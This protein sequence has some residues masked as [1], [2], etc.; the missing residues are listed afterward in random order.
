MPV[1]FL[2]EQAP[3]K[4]K[5]RFLDEERNTQQFGPPKE[6]TGGFVSGVAMGA[7]DPVYGVGQMVPRGMQWLTSLGGN[8]PNTVSDLYGKSAKTVD[9]AVKSREEKYQDPEG[10]DWGR[11][12]GNVASPINFIPAGS[13]GKVSSLGGKALAGVA[14]GAAFGAAQ[15]VAETENYTQKKAWQTGLGAAGGA[16]APAI[17]AGVNRLMNPQTAPA[18]KGLL[19]EGVKMTPGQMAGGFVKRAED[20]FTSIPVLGDVINS[21]KNKSIE[22]LNLT[23]INRALKPIGQS[24]PKGISAGREAIGYVGDTLG[25]AYD[26]LLPKLT[27][28]VD[29]VFSDDLSLIGDMVNADDVM[30][31]AEKTKFASII[32]NSLKKRMAANGGMTGQAIKDIE[33]E[34][35]EKAATFGHGTIQERQLA[36]SLREVQSS[37]REMLERTNPQYAKELKAIN[38]GYANFK[39]VQKAAASTGTE[40]GVFT[41][42]QLQ[43]AVKAGDRSKDKGAFAKGT[44]LMQDLSDPA[45]ARLPSKIN[46]SGTATRALFSLGALGAGGY[47]ADRMG[48]DPLAYGPVLG[49]AAMYTPAGRRM[50]QALLTERPNSVRA[51][52][53]AAAKYAPYLG[54][55]LTAPLANQK[56]D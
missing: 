1:R 8:Y 25:K 30:N 11:L 29:D 53:S 48:I 26:D 51:I 52:G 38:K 34:L 46:D 12:T 7:L 20:A 50:A 2:D 17:G 45:K 55:P 36:D 5:I 32:E 18:V 6:K 4:P 15:P 27:G 31:A 44:A 13:I 28:K 42:A 10:F 3:V 40:E 49:A 41:P 19:N 43:N 47:G 22:S 14:S 24:L 37:I 56:R 16:I 21:A 9:D 33:S 54:A 39:R 35:G 23:A